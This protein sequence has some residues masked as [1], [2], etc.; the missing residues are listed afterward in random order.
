MWRTLRGRILLSTVLPL[1]LV[2]FGV[3]LALIELLP[4]RILLPALAQEMVDQG[5][6][7]GRLGT[8]LPEIWADPGAAQEFLDALSIRQPTQVLLLDPSGQLLAVSPLGGF[9]PGEAAGGAL[10]QRAQR[11]EIAWQVT[12]RGGD[13]DIVLDVVIPVSDEQGH[14]LG[15]VR[16]LRRPSDIAVGLLRTRL[17]VLGTLGIGLLLSGLVSVMLAQS[18]SR[19]LRQITQA[20]AQAP[21]EG[22]PHILPESG[23]QE[24]RLLI[25]TF[26]RLQAQRAQLEETRRLMLRGIVHEFGRLIGALR[27]AL[28]ALQSGAV[29]DPALRRELLQGMSQTTVDLTRLLEDLV[30]TAPRGGPLPLQRQRFDP[31]PWLREH[32]STWAAAARSRGLTWHEEIPSRLPYLDGDPERLAQALGNL[33]DNAIKFTPAGGQVTLRAFLEGHELRFQVQDTGPGIPPHERPRLFEPF[34]RGSHEGR[35][36]LGL[37]L[38]LARMIA[39][40]HGG[41]IE[42]ESQ[43]S[44]GSTFTLV[45]PL[46]P[47]GKELPR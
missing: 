30:R 18:V 34:Y 23:P 2:A 45:V 35:P 11:G 44:A 12:L 10:F 32:A 36:G 27:A 3:G 6:L 46:A 33:V 40:A 24:V 1:L 22:P 16:L 13:S 20:I 43:P 25:R 9:S 42:V 19:P 4:E 14:R 17:L 15:Y 21:L 29:E 41:R 5:I 31:V 26:N 47:A 28:H 38:F 7:I 37:G 39:E 8:L